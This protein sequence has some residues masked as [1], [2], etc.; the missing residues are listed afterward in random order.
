[1]VK[2]YLNVKVTVTKAQD[3]DWEIYHGFYSYEATKALAAS[4]R[5]RGYKARASLSRVIVNDE[6]PV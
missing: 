4:L 2:Y 3:P 5:K 6:T 1:M